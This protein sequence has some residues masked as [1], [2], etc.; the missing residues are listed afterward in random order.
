MFLK[1]KYRGAPEVVSSQE[2]RGRHE[3][4]QVQAMSH[5]PTPGYLPNTFNPPRLKKAIGELGLGG[6]NPGARRCRDGKVAGAGPP[7][8]GANTGSN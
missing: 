2:V 6:G 1:V 5:G 8:L 7:R 3:A 4:S